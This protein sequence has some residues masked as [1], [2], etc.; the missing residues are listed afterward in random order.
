MRDQFGIQEITIFNARQAVVA[1]A[2]SSMASSMAVAPSAEIMSQANKVNGVGFVEELQGTQ[3]Y[4]LKAVIP[5]VKEKSSGQ[6]F[7]LSLQYQRELWYL[8]LIKRVPDEITKNTLAVQAAY[9]DYQEKSLG[10]TGLPCTSR[11]SAPVR[12][13]TRGCS[14]TASS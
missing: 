10:R 9:S 1:T 5:L 2:S 14:L 11:L 4:R 8:Q 6:G 3:D 13:T 12:S 7:G